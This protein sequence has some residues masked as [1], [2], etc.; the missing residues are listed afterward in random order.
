MTRSWEGRPWANERTCRRRATAGSSRSACATSWRGEDGWP[1][2]GVGVAL[3]LLD[4][5][6]AAA[7]RAPR[8][9][10]DAVRALADLVDVPRCR[11]V[12]RWD[13]ARG[14]HYVD[15][16]ACRFGSRACRRGTRW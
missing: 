6:T 10:P 12:D 4:V 5:V 2:E 7:P 11:L 16:T 8:T 13:A 14:R 3:G 1:T 9:V 15:C